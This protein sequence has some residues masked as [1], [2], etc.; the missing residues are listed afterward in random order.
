MRKKIVQ[1][2]LLLISIIG[3]STNCIVENNKPFEVIDSSYII[4]P[5]DIINQ[6]QPSVESSNVEVVGESSALET[7][8][9]EEKFIEKEFEQ[10]QQLIDGASI[11]IPNG[12][13]VEE[14][15]DDM[16]M[17]ALVCVSEA[18]GE[19]EYGKRLVIDTIFNRLDSEY[20]PNN[21]HDILYAPNQYECVS[22]GR[23]DRVEYNVYIANLVLEEYQHRTNTEVIYFRTD[24][25][26]DFGKPLFSEGHHWFSGR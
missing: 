11:R 19:S 21:I 12:Y 1:C 14:F 4:D 26:F 16:E 18:E 10:E 25:Y 7:T 22:N 23:I 20:F 2:L 8:A 6:V 9:L 3:I 24:H 17:V 15:W 5:I 13:D